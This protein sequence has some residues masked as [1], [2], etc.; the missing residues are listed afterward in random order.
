MPGEMSAQKTLLQKLSSVV[1]GRVRRS[2]AASKT[3]VSP[4]NNSC[5]PQEGTADSLR[6]ARPFVTAGNE[7]RRRHRPLAL[8]P[9]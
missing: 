1:G 7:A 4:V 9:G 6:W 2:P 3:P 8:T 5:W